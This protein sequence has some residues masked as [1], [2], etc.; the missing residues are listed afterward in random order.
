MHTEVLL[1]EQ[2]VQ[3]PVFYVHEMI[4]PCIS[5]NCSTVTRTPLSC[6]L[7][8]GSTN[9]PC[10]LTEQSSL[11]PVQPQHVDEGLP[12]HMVLTHRFLSEEV[13]A[14][15]SWTCPL[16]VVYVKAECFSDALA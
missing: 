13:V 4:H 9:Q 8:L 5:Q 10:P 7:S 14:D 2:A 16:D 1:G 12:S 11:L 15:P 6:R 3:L